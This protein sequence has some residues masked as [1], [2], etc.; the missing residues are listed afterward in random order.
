MHGDALLRSP[1]LLFSA[2]FCSV[3]S[4]PSLPRFPPGSNQIFL[5]TNVRSP[6][7]KPTS[8][9]RVASTLSP[10]FSPAL[11]IQSPGEPP[12]GP[13]IMSSPP[14]PADRAVFFCHSSVI[15][16]RI[17]FRLDLGEDV[18]THPAHPLF[19]LFLRIRKPIH[20]PALAGCRCPKLCQQ[21]FKCVLP[22][23][24]PRTFLFRFFPL[25]I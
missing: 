21:K 23:H 13:I 1:R 4:I 14:H 3:F 24:S 17:P 16:C 19:L 11:Q 25:I 7:K 18:A 8:C 9:S 2:G 22:S 12:L 6:E 5:N 10:A 20:K 15:V